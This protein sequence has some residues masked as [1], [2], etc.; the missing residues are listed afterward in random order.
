M[1]PCFVFISGTAA[2]GIFYTAE[3]LWAVSYAVH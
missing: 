3:A 2:E 1:N